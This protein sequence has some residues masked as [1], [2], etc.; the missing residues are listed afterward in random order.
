MKENIK[1]ILILFAIFGMIAVAG[2]FYGFSGD[3]VMCVP[4]QVIK[5]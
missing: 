2:S 1:D 3:D 5:F 4:S